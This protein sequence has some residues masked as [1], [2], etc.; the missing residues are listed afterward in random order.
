VLAGANLTD[1]NTLGEPEKVT[2]VVTTFAGAAADFSRTFP[3]HSMT[4][5]RIQGQ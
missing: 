1:M 2:P 4:I 3:P 5:L